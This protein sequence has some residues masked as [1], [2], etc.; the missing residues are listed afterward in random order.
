MTESHQAMALPERAQ[1]PCRAMQLSA[2]AAASPRG[3]SLLR[4]TEK[5]NRKKSAYGKVDG[6]RSLP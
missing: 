4:P 2:S 5:A 1:A 3:R 6:G